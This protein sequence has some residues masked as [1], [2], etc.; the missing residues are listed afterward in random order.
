ME[1]KTQNE[2]INNHNMKI[3]NFIISTISNKILQYVGGA[4][5]TSK[6]HI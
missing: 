1:I 3:L 5:G 6:T 4:I 2:N